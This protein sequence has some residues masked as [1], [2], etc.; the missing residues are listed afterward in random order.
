MTGFTL[1][2]LARL[3]GGEIAG[4][5]ILCPGP[6]HSPGDRS[7]SIRLSTTAADGFVCHSFAGDDF[8]AC[9]DFVRERLGLTATHCRR[10]PPLRAAAH[11]AAIE[12]AAAKAAAT[13][14]ALALWLEGIDSRG[15][16]VERYLNGR[17]LELG[18][19]TAGH[20]LRWHPRIGAMLALFRSVLTGEP[21]AISRTFLDSEGKKLGRKF[22]GPVLGAAVML[23][24][25]D[26]VTHGLFIGEGVETCMAA[27]QLNLRPVWAL[28]SS[29]G[30]KAFPIL[31]GVECLTLLKEADDASAKACAACAARWHATGREV[32]INSP[33]SGKDL[34]D[35]IRVRGAS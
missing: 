16:V 11:R 20:V 4:R 31:S 24:P 3:L 21:R 8:R 13:H 35:A 15:T 34:N 10:D 29:G 33:T 25:F 27:R 2:A 9:R 26:C 32:F 23:D 22:L 12:D 28:G 7:L 6:G 18:E 14:Q 5:Q 19:D 30:V 17:G 1:L